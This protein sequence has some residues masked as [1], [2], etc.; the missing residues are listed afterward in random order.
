MARLLNTTYAAILRPL[1]FR[2]GPET[3]HRFVLALLS[4]VPLLAPLS[5]PP[6]LATTLFGLSF[7]N[8]VGLAA[9]MDKDVRAVG[10]WQALG[11]G[12][13]ELGTITPRPQP[14]NPGKRLWRLAEHR[15]LINRLGFPS[16]GMEA[17]QRRL[18]ALA[19]PKL[20]IRLAL[21]LGPNRETPVEQVAQEYASLV[22]KLGRFADFVVANVSSPNTP[23]LTSWQT[24]ERLGAV[25]KAMRA[26]GYC[27]PLLFKVSPD[28]DRASL[29]DICDAAQALG[30]DGIVAT[31]TTLARKDVGVSAP[32]EGGLSGSPLK[33]RARQ[34]IRDIRTFTQGKLTI[35]G[36]GGAGSAQDAYEHIRAGASL[37][38]LYTALVYHGP[39]LIRE[40]KEGLAVLLRRD[41]FRT[42]S[43]AVGKE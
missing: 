30:V 6:E 36:V 2:L 19:R 13:A 28:L 7:S 17:A 34:V 9:G 38:E 5:D 31:N 26:A 21:S 33:E 11:F 10:A 23:G 29:R 27:G 20:R 24:P 18:E 8:P 3:A 42:I 37:I 15:A 40:L 1:L 14:G 16:A 39:G 43:E 32:Q 12:F 35:I 4:R 22:N 25:V 41:G